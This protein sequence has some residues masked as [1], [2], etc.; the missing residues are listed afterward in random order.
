MVL[1]DERAASLKAWAMDW[2]SGQ[3]TAKDDVLSMVPVSGDASFRRYFRLLLGD[4]SLIAVDAPPDKE[5]SLPFVAIA[6][7]LRAHE[8]LVPEIIAWNRAE[9]FL[10]LSDFGD[11]LLLGQMTD[12]S[13]DGY[14]QQAFVEILQ[15]QTCQDVPGWSLPSYDRQ[16]LMDEM[17]LFRDWF[18]GRYLNLSLTIEQHAILENALDMIVAAV[19]EMPQVFVHRDYHSRNIMV[20]EDGRLG[21]IDFQD[22]VTGAV[23]YDLISLLR[24]AYIVWPAERV[25]GWMR[26][27]AAMARQRGHLQDIDDDSFIVMCDWMSAQRHLKVIGIFARLFLRDGKPGYLQDIPRVF[28]YL[29]EEIQPYP[30][31][32]A[33]EEL[34]RK[35]ILPAYLAREPEAGELLSVW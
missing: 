28:N 19:L 33:V 4:S 11:V 35:T 25:R 10:L 23:T 27:F 22:A 21:I 15:M 32:R 3:G 14:Y 31:F 1:N 29:L 34:L 9:G 6:S 8:V 26:E 16:R 2:L 12:Q 13:V 20:L 30:A 5:N 17:S 24:D 18:V 7:A